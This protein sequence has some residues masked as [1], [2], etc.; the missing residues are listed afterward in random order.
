MT[1]KSSLLL[2]YQKKMEKKKKEFG[3]IFTRL[4]FPTDIF[5]F[6]FQQA[7]QLFSPKLIVVH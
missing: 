1:R 3:C 7:M 5:S 2:S 6:T 4:S